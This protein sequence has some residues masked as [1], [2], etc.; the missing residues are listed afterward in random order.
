MLVFLWILLVSCDNVRSSVTFWQNIGMQRRL[1]GCN[2]KTMPCIFKNDNLEEY[3][4][5]FERLNL[6]TANLSHSHTNPSKEIAPAVCFFLCATLIAEGPCDQFYV[7]GDPL[8]CTPLP[9]LFFSEYFS[10][11]L[12]SIA[13]DE[14]A[15]P[16]C[17]QCVSFFLTQLQVVEQGCASC[18]KE[19][20]WSFHIYHVFSF[21]TKRANANRAAAVL[22]CLSLNCFYCLHFH[23]EEQWSTCISP[24]KLLGRTV[25]YWKT[26]NCCILKHRFSCYLK[27]SDTEM[28]PKVDMEG[29]VSGHSLKQCNIKISG[30]I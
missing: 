12:V 21:A 14:A 3:L 26:V 10:L 7:S 16:L 17:A 9:Y 27:D 22:P 6:A 15:F 11:D 24:Q 13:W 28:L 4:L 2:R 30:K 29:A 19:T 18:L 25:L 23:V 1:Q 5:N 20:F 8:Y